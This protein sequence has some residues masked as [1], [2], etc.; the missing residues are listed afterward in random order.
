MPLGF[1]KN[2]FIS[3]PITIRSQNFGHF[4]V[5]PDPFLLCNGNVAKQ[6]KSIP[7]LPSFLTSSPW[8]IPPSFTPSSDIPLIFPSSCARVKNK[9]LPNHPRNPFMWDLLPVPEPICIPLFP[10]MWQVILSHNA[11]ALLLQDCH[12]VFT[13]GPQEKKLLVENRACRQE[14]LIYHLAQGVIILLKLRQ[15][16]HLG[17]R[18]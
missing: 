2:F 7:S 11:F 4:Q 15:A 18:I 6:L 16:W 5:S 8:Y 10:A 13:S 9:S 12:L 14:L 1:P 17:D 3:F